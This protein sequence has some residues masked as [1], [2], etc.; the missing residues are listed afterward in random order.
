MAKT[1]PEATR[2]ISRSSLKEISSEMLMAFFPTP[3]LIEDATLSNKSLY[4]KVGPHCRNHQ[5]KL[6]MAVIYD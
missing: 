6:I 5:G 2:S 3:E 4:R 1:D